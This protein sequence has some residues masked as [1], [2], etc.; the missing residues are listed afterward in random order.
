M[1]EIFFKDF[2]GCR[3][4]AMSVSMENAFAEVKKK[5]TNVLLQ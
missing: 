4:R 5:A 3:L 1:E 2:N